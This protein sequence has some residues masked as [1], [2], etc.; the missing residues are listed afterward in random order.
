MEEQRWLY[1]VRDRDLGTRY[2]NRQRGVN[3]GTIVSPNKGKKMTEEQKQKISEALK[4]RD[5]VPPKT[6]KR[7]AQQAIGRPVSEEARRKISE[8]QK[9]KPKNPDSIK[10]MAETRKGQPSWNKG[11]TWNDDIRMKIANTLT[12][13]KHTDEARLNMSE[14]RK[15]WWAEK[16]AMAR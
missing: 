15:R 11:K 9:G 5:V 10:K 4:G 14:S 16:K 3:I 1:M 2:Y 12:G 6:R 7:L 8:K 13:L